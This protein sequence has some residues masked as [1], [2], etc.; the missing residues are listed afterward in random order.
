[1]KRYNGQILLPENLVLTPTGTTRHKPILDNEL[2]NMS[3]EQLKLMAEDISN[4]GKNSQHYNTLAE[5]A[6]QGLRK[7]IHGTHTTFDARIIGLYQDED[8]NG[9]KIG[10]TLQLTQSLELLARFDDDKQAKS[11]WKNS[12]IRYWLNGEFL[13]K[14]FPLEF[15]DLLEKARKNTTYAYTREGGTRE[16][17]T[18]DKLFLPSTRELYGATDTSGYPTTQEGTGKNNLEQYYAYKKQTR[19]SVNLSQEI[20]DDDGNGVKHMCC[21]RAWTRTSLLALGNNAIACYD[22]NGQVKKADKTEYLRVAPC[23]CL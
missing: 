13:H 17:Q 23:F 22:N 19:T 5:C 11:C 12:E 4:K 1:M 15:K 16:Y 3:W 10:V 7:R 9:K 18:D 14:Q 21:D 6:Q 8:P 20:F 2:E